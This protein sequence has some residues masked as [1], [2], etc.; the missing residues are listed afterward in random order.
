[1]KKNPKYHCLDSKEDLRR[2]VKKIKQT[3]F[4]RPQ[5]QELEDLS[6]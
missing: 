2:I 5:E 3:K 4:F 1:M 6:I